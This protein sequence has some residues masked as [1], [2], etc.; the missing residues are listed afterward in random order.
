[1]ADLSAQ[2]E[3]SLGELRAA[4]H[5]RDDHVIDRCERQVRELLLANDNYRLIGDE[6][7]LAQAN[8][9]L[10]SALGKVADTD[11]SALRQH[12]SVLQDTYSNLYAVLDTDLDLESL[13]RHLGTWAIITQH[14]SCNFDEA[15][16]GELHKARISGKSEQR[17]ETFFEIFLNAVRTQGLTDV[18]DQ[19]TPS[20]R[21][22][23]DGY[24]RLHLWPVYILFAVGDMGDV[25]GAKITSL[26]NGSGGIR[27]INTIGEDMQTSARKAVEYV[28]EKRPAT[29]SWD[30]RLEISRGDIQF[31]GES[32]GLGITIATLMNVET[33]DVDPFTAFTG[34]VDTDGS[35]KRIEHL[36]AKLQAA[37]AMGVRR[38]FIPQENEG[39]YKPIDGLKIIPVISV[40]DALTKLRNTT[41]RQESN[42]LKTLAENKIQELATILRSDGV[43]LVG[44][45]DH[46]DSCIRVEFTDHRDRAVVMVYHTNALKPVPQGKE[47]PL[48][49]KIQVACDDI[50]GKKIPAVLASTSNKPETRKYTVKISADQQKLLQHLMKRGDG[51]RE[52]ENNCLYRLKITKG[53]QTTYVRQ[54]TNGTLT[55]NG[56]SPLL[57]EVDADI[58]V[59][60]GVNDSIPSE[61]RGDDKLQAQIEAVKAVELGETWIGTDEAGKGDY[62]GPLVAAAV[63]VD[64]R[65][66][67]Q[68]QALGVKD[69]KSSSD[70]RN[71]ELAEAIRRICGKRAQ[72]VIIPPERYNTLYDQFQHEGKNLN[73]LL[74]WG[75]TRALEDILTEYP[76]QQITVIVDKFGDEH[77]VRSRLLSRSREAKLNLVQMPKAEANIAVAA[78]SVLA[79]AQFLNYLAKMSEQYRIDFPKGSSDP[80]I[81]QIG[82]EIISRLGADELRKV[83]KLHFA[84][85]Q[86][87]LDRK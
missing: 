64:Q 43:H 33:L 34:R 46:N 66:A 45:G 20:I 11:L 76:Q 59:V 15:I 50:F 13:L 17:L 86:K 61:S 4:L 48:R 47:S 74:A 84:T 36:S 16:K 78:A 62:Y 65:L 12:L 25:Y 63:L 49:Q 27:S 68:L 7:L 19:L 1:M 28:T 8:T 51:V 75:H 53:G 10:T 5:E 57:D 26:P 24:K 3:G 71:L 23:I 58:K 32:I 70:K 55:V 80:R 2:L 85:T 56:V 79:R 77:Y 30:F 40:E 14:I 72:V 69:S 82:G 41:Y 73:T 52:I 42:N 87:I 44:Q 67:D 21:Q 31:D 81:V 29:R 9:L 35:V 54:F 22:A 38:V 6:R 83:A 18:A 60:I 37:H 39:E